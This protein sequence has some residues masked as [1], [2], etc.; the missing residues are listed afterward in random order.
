MLTYETG[1]VISKLGKG[2]II[3]SNQYGYLGYYGY[4]YFRPSELKTISDLNDLK[5]ILLNNGCL[6]DWQ[7]YQWCLNNFEKLKDMQDENPN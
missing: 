1:I 7:T 2:K 6:I 3:L 4:K 5:S